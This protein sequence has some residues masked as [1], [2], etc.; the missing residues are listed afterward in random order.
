MVSPHPNAQAAWGS[1][2]DG[3]LLGRPEVYFSTLT[4]RATPEF[5][6]EFAQRITQSACQLARQRSVYMVRPIPEMGF[7]VPNTLSRRMVLGLNNDLSISIE[8]YKAR[9]AW[10]C[11]AQDAARDQCGIKILDP[12]AILCRDGRCWASQNGR[13]LYSDYDHL[14][15]FGNKLLVPMFGQ[16]FEGL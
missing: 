2:T 4:D 12:T 15:E 1:N 8:D 14:S 11:A 3:V 7:D 13:S 5:W 6:V 9:N 16:V 10:V